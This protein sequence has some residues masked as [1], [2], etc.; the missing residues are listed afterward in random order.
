[1]STTKPV[2][3]DETL[4]RLVEA[5]L[6]QNAGQRELRDLM[7]KQNKLLEGITVGESE[8]YFAPIKCTATT[9]DGVTTYAYA[10]D[11]IGFDDIFRAYQSGKFV[12]LCISSGEDVYFATFADFKN[13]TVP[14]GTSQTFTFFSH[15]LHN[16]QYTVLIYRMTKNDGT[17]ADSLS[18]NP[19]GLDARRFR[20]M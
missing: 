16:K 8:I 11:G 9:A 13:L 15:T 7:E 5:I 4:Q 19:S 2:A 14:I 17:V 20:A 12:I 3:L 18:V 1:M 10:F 6:S